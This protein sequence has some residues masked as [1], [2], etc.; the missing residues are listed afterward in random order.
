MQ[1]VESGIDPQGR[2]HYWLVLKFPLRDQLGKWLLGGIALDITEQHQ[3]VEAMRESEERFRATFEQAAVGIA[4]VSVAG[5][6]LRVNQKL[7][8]ILGRTAEELLGQPVREVTAPDD[9]EADSALIS[10]LLSGTISTYTTE[11]RLRRSDCTLI[12]ARMT[13]SVMRQPTGNP[14]YLIFVVEDVTER[15][16]TEDERR[17]LEASLHQTENMAAMGSLVSGV[18]HQ[19]RNPLFGI[20]ATLDACEARMGERE[21]LRPYLKVLRGE[22]KRLDDLMRDLL[23]YGRP[24]VQEF[25]RDSIEEVITHSIC[26]CRALAEN[27]HVLIKLHNEQL[28]PPI[29]MHRERLSQA[30]INLLENAIQHSPPGGTVTIEVKEVWLDNQ[31]W[32]ECS[33]QDCGSG[34]RDDDLPR[35]FEPFF[36]RRRKGTGLGLAIVR[37]IVEEHRG[38]LEAGNRAQ[39]GAAVCLLFPVT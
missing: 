4:H 32:V 27:S 26:S 2:L 7:C 38:R 17:R 21:E 11:K 39:G 22:I 9:M 25:T 28:L 30:F 29:L 33:V 35:I 24:S 37:R 6:W 16:R 12:L 34:F 13:V 20:T 14:K 15:Q 23:E 18:A 31:Q 3:S 19:V 5:Q 1:E 10:H 8:E 36:T